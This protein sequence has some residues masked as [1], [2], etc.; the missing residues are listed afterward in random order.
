MLLPVITACD[1]DFFG[2]SGKKDS[3]AGV[4]KTDVEIDGERREITSFLLDSEKKITLK[5]GEICHFRD[6][7]KQSIPYRWAYYIS[8]ESV[9]GFYHSDYGDTTPKNAGNGGDSGWRVFYFEALAPGSCVITV[10]YGRIDEQDTNYDYEYKYS[11]EVTKDGSGDNAGE[12]GEIIQFGGYDWRVLEVRDGKALV[13]SEDIVE[14]NV[15]DLAAADG[16]TWETSF[17][18]TYL[19]GI[20]LEKFT[21]EEQEQIAVTRIKN[22]DNLWYGTPGGADTDDKIFLLSLEEAEKYFGGGGD[23]LNERRKSWNADGTAIEKNDSGRAVSDS[24]DSERK[25]KYGYDFSWWWLR[26]PGAV[27]LSAACVSSD[28]SISVS[29]RDVD[30]MHPEMLG[31]RPALWLNPE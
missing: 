29:G 3:D 13:I 6:D 5:A 15:Y 25:A 23:Y 27:N 30:T 1:F 9:M 2:L 7:E 26:S 20:F 17:L 4:I 16:V 11:V 28:G 21:A 10:R 19:N 8:D 24:H 31:V 14:A 22:P 12:A 18:R